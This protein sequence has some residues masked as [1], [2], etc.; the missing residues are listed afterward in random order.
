MFSKFTIRPFLLL[1]QPLSRERGWSFRWNPP[2]SLVLFSQKTFSA[3]ERCCSRNPGGSRWPGVWDGGNWEWGESH[4][5]SIYGTWSFVNEEEGFIIVRKWTLHEHSSFQV[6]YILRNLPPN[7]IETNW[8]SWFYLWLWL[9]I[10]QWKTE[11][12]TILDVE[13]NGVM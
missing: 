1:R 12:A 7:A 10:I 2:F 13:I 3:G 11:I 8:L 6:W 4:R 9:D 5:E